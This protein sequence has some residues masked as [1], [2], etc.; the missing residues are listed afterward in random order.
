MVDLEDEVWK[1]VVGYGELFSVSDKGRLF[2]KRTNKI[3]KQNIVGN[4]YNACVT[5]L[6][7]RKGSNLVLKIHREVAKAFIPNPDELPFVNHIDGDKLNNSVENLEWVTPRE[8]VVHALMIGLSTT[9]HLKDFGKSLRKL[10]EDEVKHIKTCYKSFDR[11]FGARA[12]A[13]SY[14]VN[15]GTI[16]SIV[17]GETYLDVA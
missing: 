16:L 8:N 3:L 5:K 1:D 15:K 10:T 11:E 9:D 2:S 17:K 6:N 7:G 14:G 4:G 13:K 12:L